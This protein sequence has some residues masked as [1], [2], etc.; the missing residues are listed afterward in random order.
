MWFNSLLTYDRLRMLRIRH[1]IH[2]YEQTSFGDSGPFAYWSD[3][4]PEPFVV[5]AAARS[6]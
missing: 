4:K 2:S 3:E 6:A 5:K 1:T